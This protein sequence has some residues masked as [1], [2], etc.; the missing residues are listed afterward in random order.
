MNKYHLI[1]T[2]IKGCNLKYKTTTNEPTE[3]N[4]EL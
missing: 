2:E 3:L 1:M 4:T